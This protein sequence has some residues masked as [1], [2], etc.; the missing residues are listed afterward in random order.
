MARSKPTDRMYV[1]EVQTAYQ[2]TNGIEYRW[3]KVD[4]EA[5]ANTD[6]VR[7]AYCEGS[8]KFLRRRKADGGVRDHVQHLS[9]QD[10]EH[11]IAGYYF[12]G[13]H[14]RSNSPVMAE[15]LR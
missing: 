14:R 7:C 12:K 8:V 1:C 5:T 11:C 4:V 3:K 6:H 9:R 2:T 10:S 13:E 15:A